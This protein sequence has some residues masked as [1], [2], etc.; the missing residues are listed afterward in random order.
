M[1]LARRLDLNVVISHS[2]GDQDGPH[3][4]DVVDLGTQHDQTP[5]RVLFTLYHE[6]CHHLLCQD[7]EFCSELHD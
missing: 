2:G 1:L 5:K 6:I 7:G 3:V 4:D